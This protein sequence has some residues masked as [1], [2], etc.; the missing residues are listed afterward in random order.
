MRSTSGDV[1][2]T[3]H[4][5]AQRITF[6]QVPAATMSYLQ[7]W[8]LPCQL[9]AMR[10]QEIRKQFLPLQTQKKSA[11]HW[12]EW[13]GGQGRIT[14]AQEQQVNL[15]CTYSAILQPT[16][17]AARK[18]NPHQRGSTGPSQGATAPHSPSNPG[19]FHAPA[20]PG[21][22]QDLPI[23]WRRMALEIPRAAGNVTVPW[24]KRHHTGGGKASTFCPC[25]QCRGRT[26]K[27]QQ[28][29]QGLPPTQRHSQLWLVQECVFGD[30]FQLPARRL[31]RTQAL[32]L[33]AGKSPCCRPG[34]CDSEAAG[35]R[36][37][38]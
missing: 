20:Q 32:E 8:H 5:K 31:L 10:A 15:S 38:S 6:R 27:T 19:F 37:D 13:T 9:H 3:L 22:Y 33:G 21:N 24:R 18:A 16:L 7:P 25:A 2:G 36:R 29:P 14:L 1:V 30:D 11:Q 26:H 35:G 28:S 23:L 12:Q 17:G 34:R 4:S